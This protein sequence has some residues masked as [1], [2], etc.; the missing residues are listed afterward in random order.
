VSPAQSQKRLAAKKIKAVEAAEIA[1]RFRLQ[2]ARF[3]K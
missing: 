1:I 3:L 2:E